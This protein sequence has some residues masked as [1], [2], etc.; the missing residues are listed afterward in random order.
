MN[1]R[2]TP[3]IKAIADAHL[4]A[5]QTGVFDNPEVSSVPEL[6]EALLQGKTSA[7]VLEQIELKYCSIGSLLISGLM[8][9]NSTNYR[10]GVYKGF[11]TLFQ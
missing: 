4:N 3:Q 6:K 1:K 9:H 2:I 11:K 8:A 10:A 7:M 5:K